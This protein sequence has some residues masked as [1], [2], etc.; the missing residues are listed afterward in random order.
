MFSIINNNK[1]ILKEFKKFIKKD[2]FLIHQEKTIQK[3]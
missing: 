1:K 2:L 3:L